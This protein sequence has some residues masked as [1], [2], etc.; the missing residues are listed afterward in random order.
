[1]FSNLEYAYI[2]GDLLLFCIWI[3]FFIARKDLRK[4]MLLISIFSVPLGFA[5]Y[6]FGADYW[7]PEYIFGHSFFGFEDLF[8]MF[9]VGGITGVIYEEFFGKKLAKHRVKSHPY[10]MLLFF[11]LGVLCFFIGNKV[12]NFNSIYVS[13]AIFLGCGI[14]TLTIRHDLFKHAFYSA[15]FLA[16]LT[17]VFD[18]L[19]LFLFPNFFKDWW[20]L[21]NLS[22]IFLIGVPIEEIL[23]AFMLG[24]IAGPMYEFVFGLRLKN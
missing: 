16:F 1:M 12:L 3:L 14:V 23:F 11:V 17:L 6:F 24:F 8:Y 22:G 18:I 7:H 9:A 5:Q 10:F 20:E 4:E 19:F 15:T 2:T 21:G 13:S